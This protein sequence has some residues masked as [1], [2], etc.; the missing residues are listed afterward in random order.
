M[1]FETFIIIRFIPQ[2]YQL[3]IAYINNYQTIVP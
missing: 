2:P 3:I 1:C